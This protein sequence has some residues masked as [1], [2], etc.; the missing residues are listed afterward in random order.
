MGR[1]IYERLGYRTVVRYRAF[2][3]P[4]PADPAAPDPERAIAG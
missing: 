2:V 3:D 1:P 4:P